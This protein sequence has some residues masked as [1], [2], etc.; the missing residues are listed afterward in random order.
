VERHL[1][2]LPV[3]EASA[4]PTVDYWRD[5]ALKLEREIEKAQK[6]STATEVLIEQVRDIAP[7][8]YSPAP[9][10]RQHVAKG[11]SSPQ[12]AVLLLSD[13]HVGAKVRAEQTLGFGEYNFDVFCRRLKRLEDS[14]ASILQDHTTTKI[15][16][17][18]IPMIGDMIDGALQHAAECGQ[19]NTLFNQFYGAGHALAQFLRNLSTLVPSIRVYTCVGNHPRW[20]TQH[21]MPTKNRFSNLDQFLYAYIEALVR[22]IPTIKFRLDQQPFAEF[23]VQGFT[24]LAAHGDHLRGG[25]KALGIPAHSI[26]RAISA[27]TQIRV[28]HERPGVNYY[29]LGHLHRPMEIPHAL[30]E[31]IV[32]GGFPGVDEF[33]LTNSFTPCSP[34]Q[35]FFFVHPTFGRSACYDLNLAKA[36]MDGPAPYNIPAGFPVL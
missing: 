31:V 20:G 1:E 6:G 13:T 24:F 27:T 16:E 36:K 28:K 32:N 21:K 11:T 26:G 25:D 4:D 14:A 3:A 7:I 2:R 33:G 17:L 19:V 18:V 12:S 23:K 8:S 5:R 35:K 34:I 15:S 22:D 10:C 30:G 9:A 29:L